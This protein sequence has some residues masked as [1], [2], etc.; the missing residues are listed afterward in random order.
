MTTHWQRSASTKSEKKAPVDTHTRS[1]G[2]ALQNVVMGSLGDDLD[3]VE[4]APKEKDQKI[5]RCPQET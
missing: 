1:K 4:P 5:G 2:S 3:A